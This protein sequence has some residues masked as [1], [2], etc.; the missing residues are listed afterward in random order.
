LT[1]CAARGPQQTVGR[2]GSHAAFERGMAMYYGFD[3]HA[4]IGWFEQAAKGDDDAALA[5]WGIALALGPNI[6]DRGM[7]TR[8]AIPPR[9]IGPT[10]TG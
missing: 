1:A 5:R 2:I 8:M 10:P 3:Y 7:Q 4:A 6:N 9:S